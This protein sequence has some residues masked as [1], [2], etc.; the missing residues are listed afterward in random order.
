MVI[1]DLD[2]KVDIKI[3]FRGVIRDFKVDIKIDFRR[4]IRECFEESIF[5]ALRQVRLT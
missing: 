4:V 1:G 2:F 5:V 3:D